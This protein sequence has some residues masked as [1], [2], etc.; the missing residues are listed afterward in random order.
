MSKKFR[1]TFGKAQHV[2]AGEMRT[3]CQRPGTVDE[4]G[5]IQYFTEQSHKKECDVNEILKKYDKT[6]LITH[7]AKFEGK[8]G[9]ITGIEFKEMNDII[10]GAKSMFETLPVEIRTYFKNDP[11]NLLE[12]MEHEENREKAIELGL[13]SKATAE[14]A[15]GF[16]EHVV[17]K[18]SNMVVDNKVIDKKVAPM[19][20]KEKEKPGK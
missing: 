11:E 17:A 6:G 10:S 16:G 13:I 15:D 3:F 12:F 20:Q 5:E 18:E 1:E 9:D 8:F 4:N 14:N 7:V 2:S 19:D